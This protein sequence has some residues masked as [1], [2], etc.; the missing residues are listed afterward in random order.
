MNRGTMNLM[1]YQATPTDLVIRATPPG[2][3]VPGGAGQRNRGQ[4]RCTV[5]MALAPCL[6]LLL[7]LLA[8]CEEPPNRIPL[9]VPPYTVEQRLVA[10]SCNGEHLAYMNDGPQAPG[11]HVLDVRTGEDQSVN[12]DPLLPDNVIS[13]SPIALIWCPYDSSRLLVLC[14]ASLWVTVPSGDTT[15]RIR[16]Y[17]Q[18][19][20]VLTFGDTA[21]NRFAVRALRPMTP[22]KYGPAGLPFY[23]IVGWLAGS[24]AVA[25][26]F[27]FGPNGIY[28]PQQDS[29][30]NDHYA[31][32]YCQSPNGRHYLGAQGV[33][34]EPPRLLIDGQVVHLE[35]DI[36][37]RTYGNLVGA[38]WTPNGNRVAITFF[39]SE[40]GIHRV[41]F[42]D[43]E[44]NPPTTRT[45]V[46]ARILPRN[47][48]IFDVAQYLTDSTLVIPIAVGDG[49]L[50]RVA[51]WEVAESDGRIVRRLTW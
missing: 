33:V 46:S 11:L 1:W 49:E 42:L 6:L 51:L 32:L 48:L 29:M 28:V 9:D 4:R 2:T 8:G 47:Y 7:A 35:P 40:N 3:V 23:G 50:K 36:F 34:S 38:S 37:G 22:T 16:G 15:R 44:R 20:Y 14:S 30:Y 27:H 41:A 39:S 21:G 17:G 10:V 25:D 19:V 18:N 43:V 24:S 12:F 31:F 26:S 5:A 13:A 45:T